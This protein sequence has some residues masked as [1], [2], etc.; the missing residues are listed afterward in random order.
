MPSTVK[1]PLLGNVPKGAVVAGGAAAVV[2]TGYL[3]YKHNKAGTGVTGAPAAGY[4]AA[5]YGYNTGLP[6]NTFYGYGANYAP[7]GVT[8][9]PVGSEYGYGAY[10]YGDYNPYT[11]QYLG[12]GGAT[13]TPPTTTTTPPATTS[14]SPKSGW[15]TVNGVKEYFSAAKNTIGRSEG[16]GK[17]KHWVVTKL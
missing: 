2:V 13:T 12:S 6:Y 8:P 14:T 10:G 3:I 17:K 5:A 15:I 16:T 1:L 9:Y 4:G 11:G 7:T